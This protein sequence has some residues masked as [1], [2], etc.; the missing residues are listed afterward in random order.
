MT[1]QMLPF[2]TQDARYAWIDPSRPFPQRA[3]VTDWASVV[4]VKTNASGSIKPQMFP[5]PRVCW[6]S[7]LRVLASSRCG[8]SMAVVRRDEPLQEEDRPGVGGRASAKRTLPAAGWA[9][10]DRPWSRVAWV[11]PLGRGLDE[12]HGAE[13]CE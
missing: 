12:G 13:T 3:Q 9:R 7:G 8:P 6:P 4:R 10:L 2:V 5:H 1:P 11:P